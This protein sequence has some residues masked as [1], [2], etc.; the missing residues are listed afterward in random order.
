MPRQSNPLPLAQ[1]IPKTLELDRDLLRTVAGDT[2]TVHSLWFVKGPEV[3][4]QKT[5]QLPLETLKRLTESYPAAPSSPPVPTPAAGSHGVTPQPSNAGGSAV[6]SS[7]P[8]PRLSPASAR[9]ASPDTWRDRF[10]HWHQTL[11]VSSLPKSAGLLLIAGLLV[12]GGS[13]YWM[14]AKVATRPPTK[15]VAATQESSTQTE[16]SQRPATDGDLAQRVVQA[17]S[18]AEQREKQQALRDDNLWQ[19]REIL[20]EAE[21]TCQRAAAG[22]DA[23]SNVELKRE[24]IEQQISERWRDARFRIRQAQGIGNLQA[25]LEATR[26]ILRM[27][28]DTEEPRHREAASLERQL[29]SK[30]KRK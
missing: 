22:L 26:Q 9:K 21:A 30:I 29:E 27:I 20:L 1:D 4:C 18:L 13:W 15:L 17:L 14:S 5:E 16:S 24:G 8:A 25:A 7:H 2:A 10:Q 3:D 19:A 28:P 23:C 6:R 12:G 11:A